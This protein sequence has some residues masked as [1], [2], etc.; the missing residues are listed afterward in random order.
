MA[1]LGMHRSH[2][3]PSEPSEVRGGVEGPGF[4][5]GLLS[6]QDGAGL[7]R[8]AVH[9]G[10]FFP[11]FGWRKFHEFCRHQLIANITQP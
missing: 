6:R 9:R 8:S 10:A 4:Q 5:I 3:E 2:H 1:F 7:R 11:D